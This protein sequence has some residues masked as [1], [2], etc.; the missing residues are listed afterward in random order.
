MK[1]ISVEKA[2]IEC[3]QKAAHFQI[4]GEYK[5]L[6]EELEAVILPSYVRIAIPV[7]LREE[8]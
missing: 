8:V 4:D 6:V 5:G 1:V 2:K 3:V 7:G